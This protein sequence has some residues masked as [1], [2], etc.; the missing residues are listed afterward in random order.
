MSASLYEIIPPSEFNKAELERRIQLKVG[1][2]IDYL[3]EKLFELADGVWIF[4][5]SPDGTII[6]TYKREPD[7]KAIQYL[8]DRVVGKPTQQVETNTQNTGVIQIQHIIKNLIDE[9]SSQSQL[10]EGT[11]SDAVS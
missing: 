8:I 4:S 1:D 11:R 10:S 3:C 6:K 5:K 7:S 2:K 9:K